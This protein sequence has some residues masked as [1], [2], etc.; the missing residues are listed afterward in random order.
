MSGGY[1]NVFEEHKIFSVVQ[2]R[3]EGG[4]PVPGAP[5]RGRRRRSWQA[6]VASLTEADIP[7]AEDDLDGWAAPI[8]TARTNWPT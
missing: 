4:E 2:S 5:H 1:D 8:A 6:A 3:A 7:P